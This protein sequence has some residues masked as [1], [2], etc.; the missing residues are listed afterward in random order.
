MKPVIS[1]IVLFAEEALTC[2]YTIETGFYQYGFL[3]VTRNSSNSFF[4]EHFPVKGE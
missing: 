4:A 3:A 2:K 1:L